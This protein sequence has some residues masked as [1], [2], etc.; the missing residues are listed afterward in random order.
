MDYHSVG[1]NYLCRMSTPSSDIAFTPRVKSIQAERGSRPNYAR[2]EERGGFRTELTEDLAQFL[3]GIDTAFL[4]TANA[5]GQ[6]YTQHRGGPKGFIRILGPKTLGF[7][8]YKGNRQYITTGNLAENDRAFLFLMDYAHR[9][10][11][12]LWGRARVVADDD[13]LV[14]RLMPEDY[15]ARPEQ[16]ILFEVE[17]WDI[18]CPQHIP[19]K[20]DGADVA[21]VLAELQERIAAL[22]A[23]NAALRQDHS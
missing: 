22:E 9:R 6:P 14:A 4:A 3:A 17:A 18:N 15:E 16:A 7:A 23:E 10:R 21:R 2:M 19:Q 20:I 1:N 11:V 12:K 8:D 5:A 13:G